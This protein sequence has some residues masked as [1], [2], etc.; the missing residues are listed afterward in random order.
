MNRTTPRAA[1]VARKPPPENAIEN[2]GSTSGAGGR[3]GWGSFTPH[4]WIR[5]LG[6]VPIVG[7]S[8]GEVSATS[9]AP[10]R[11]RAALVDDVH[12][13]GPGCTSER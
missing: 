7:E 4:G 1:S 11:T 2:A 5:S 3:A 12:G 6:A 9:V 13:H 8:R 10:E